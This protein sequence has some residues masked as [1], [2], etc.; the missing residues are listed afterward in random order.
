MIGQLI[1]FFF[2]F[3]DKLKHTPPLFFFGHPSIH[4]SRQL[5]SQTNQFL[6]HTIDGFAVDKYT[7]R[8][9]KKHFPGKLAFAPAGRRRHALMQILTFFGVEIDGQTSIDILYCLFQ[10]N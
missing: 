5:L 8:L 6:D 2:D 3:H 1:D 7:Y 4:Q 10:K 9:P